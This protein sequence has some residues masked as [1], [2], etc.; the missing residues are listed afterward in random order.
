M[1]FSYS[2][3]KDVLYDLL[4]EEVDYYYKNLRT[5]SIPARFISFSAMDEQFIHIDSDMGYA[6]VSESN[7]RKFCPFISFGNKEEGDRINPYD[8]SEED[9]RDSQLQV[10]DLPLKNDSEAIK[11]VI[12]NTLGRLYRGTLAIWLQSSQHT[13]RT[14]IAIKDSL[15]TEV[16]YEEPLEEL[17]FSKERWKKLLNEVTL[18]QGHKMPEATCRAFIEC[19][20]QRRYIVDSEGTAVVCNRRTYTLNLYVSVKDDK[21]VE[22]PV[23]K[24]YFGFE[25]SDMPDETTLVADMETLA[26]RALSLSKAPMAEV[27][28]GPAI[29]SGNASAVLFHEVMGHRLE[30]LD[31][32]FM[33]M[34]GSLVMSPEFSIICN[35]ML[36]S[37]NGTQLSGYYL[38]DDEGTRGQKVECIKDGVMKDFLTCR[39]QVNSNNG[40]GRSSFGY[41]VHPR[42]SN[43][44]V[45][46]SHPY[47]ESQ[48]REMLVAELKHSKK[49]FGYYISSVSNGWTV[50][51]DN[52]KV[53]S[54][55]VVPV[56][57]YKVYADGRE[58]ELV[59]GL[60]II[61]TPL[62]MLSNIKAGGGNSEVFNGNCGSESGWIPVAC[63]APMLY[64]S[65]IE[66]QS[67][68]DRESEPA[69]HIHQ[70]LLPVSK[71]GT[72]D[73]DTMI[74]RAME[75]ELNRCSEVVEN[76]SHPMFID[77]HIRR[78][79]TT[80]ISS[81]NG[82]CFKFKL[83]GV[84][85]SGLVHVIA[86]NR[87]QTSYSA[88][89]MGK[90]FNLPDEISY[91]H[92][93]KELGNHTEAQFKVA[94]SWLERNKRDIEDSFLPEWL[95]QPS[96]T[97][98]QTSALK[99][100]Q[101]DA[102]QLKVLADTLSAVF[103]FYPLLTDT[104][105]E[106]EQ[107]YVDC[108]RV[109]SE[110]LK[111]R[112]PSKEITITAFADIPLANGKMLKKRDGYVAYDVADLPSTDSLVAFVEHFAQ[113]VI[114]QSMAECP[115]EREY[116]GPVL[117]EN[118]AAMM[119]FIDEKTLEEN[120][121]SNT[122][123]W[124]KLTSREYSNSY[125]KIGNKIISSNISVK[126]LANDS[127]YEGHR[128]MRYRSF[129]ADGVCPQTVELVHNGILLNQLAG[130][131]P[132]PKALNSTG[133]EYL[134]DY[135][136]TNGSFP[137]EYRTGVISITANKTMRHRKLQKKL[138]SIAKQNGLPYA[139]ILKGKGVLTRVD[140]KSGKEELLRICCFDSPSNLELMDNVMASKEVTSNREK[141][142]IHPQYILLPMAYLT[143]NSIDSSHACL[144]FLELKQ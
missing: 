108:Y 8:F 111:T 19:Q 93:R 103:E 72:D 119:A 33:S 137:T 47:S 54:F 81:S 118:S 25:E 80:Q 104:H 86:G 127:L 113:L 37:F 101:E 11:K 131:V 115:N 85:N 6:S 122:H 66:T 117:Y 138:R 34:K 112:T 28:S 110:G 100:W 50:T 27:Y 97:V 44:I 1:T 52:R 74:F 68:P 126:Q 4:R 48:L 16:Y 75:D 69:T 132:S 3:T 39:S 30:R 12:W 26:L 140:T 129:D 83:E 134:T 91:F 62:A 105:V 106:I 14:S 107:K 95:E 49:E 40:H 32:E 29:L 55:N 133:N 139:Y 124:L 90:P 94:S 41:E 128:L 56:E 125:K 17:R 79:A 43:L 13:T 88:R 38:Y 67:V 5:D 76:G 59:R 10:A 36:R 109:T 121:W 42:Q 71:N 130:R 23:S 24:G 7:S 65:Q 102:L 143:F 141:S 89:N 31:S 123:S 84:K 58:D 136:S 20:S 98:I 64:V 116:T 18:G 82:S 57:T 21:G 70:N 35:P 2:Q 142:V 135:W 15:L 51:G 114:A 73:S 53:T 46:T 144:R 87:L 9:W 63:V 120:L 78:Q 77:F 99:C 96:R 22:C 92:I 60:S 61:G 45:E